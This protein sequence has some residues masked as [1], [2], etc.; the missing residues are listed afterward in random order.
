MYALRHVPQRY[1]TMAYIFRNSSANCQ[2]V[3][4]LHH[5]HRRPRPLRREGPA[6][7]RAVL[8]QCRLRLRA[9]L[10]RP[11]PRSGPPSPPRGGGWGEG[12]RRGPR[13]TGVPGRADDRH[14]QT[15]AS[16]GQRLSG[17]AHARNRRSHR[18]AEQQDQAPELPG[19]LIKRTSSTLRWKMCW[20]C[21]ARIDAR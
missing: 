14:E 21:C 15:E 16:R 20:P 3:E 10:R 18:H 7:V 11:P 13:P 6:A 12:F 2:S 5:P 19:R 9:G 8:H 1:Y 4:F 17:L